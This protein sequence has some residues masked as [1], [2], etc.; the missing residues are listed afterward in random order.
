LILTLVGLLVAIPAVAFFMA[1]LRRKAHGT[2]ADFVDAGPVDS[3]PTGEYRAVSLEWVQQ[4]GWRRATMR[5]SVWVRRLSDQNFL[6]LSSICPHL[7][8][9]INWAPGQNNFVCPCHGGIFNGDGKRTAGPPPRDMDP[10][11]YEARAGRLWIRWQD[12]KIGVA[13]RVPVNV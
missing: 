4:D 5:Q 11:D 2:G 3:F 8:C 12:F 6:V 13:E 10:L 7:G 1:P 9:P